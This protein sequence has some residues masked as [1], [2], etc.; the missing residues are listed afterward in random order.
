MEKRRDCMTCFYEFKSPVEEPCVSCKG[1]AKWTD[2]STF[3]EDVVNKPKHYNVGLEPIEAIESWKLGYNLGNVISL[4]FEDIIDRLK[5]LDEVTIL[6]LLDLK[7][8]DIV[9]RF[10]DVIEDA[11]EEIEKE[12]Q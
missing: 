8:E 11:I 3:Q 4:T 7:T 10:R 9:D 12:L 2:K 1:F 5:Q 6:E